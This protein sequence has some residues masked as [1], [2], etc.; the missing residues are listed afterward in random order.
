MVAVINKAKD[1]NVI[2]DA[3]TK[4]EK[5]ISRITSDDEKLID[6]MNSIAE[7]VPRDKREEVQYSIFLSVKTAT[8]IPEITKKYRIYHSSNENEVIRVAETWINGRYNHDSILEKYNPE[9]NTWEEY[10]E[11]K[12]TLGHVKDQIQGSEWKIKQIAFDIETLAKMLNELADVG[13]LFNYD[14]A[15]FVHRILEDYSKTLHL[16]TDKIENVLNH[17]S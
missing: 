10:Q 17:I 8:H 7:L 4:N 2:E 9:S 15:M 14:G 5:K 11:E 6:A 1:Q 16:E 12:P 3:N 13:G